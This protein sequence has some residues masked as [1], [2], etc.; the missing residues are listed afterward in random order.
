MH[1]QLTLRTGAYMCHPYP[2]E[3]F[4]YIQAEG[5]T[6]QIQKPTSSGA[7]GDGGGNLMGEMSAIL[8]RR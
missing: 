5:E 8:A 3:M 4:L 7:S 1:T 2:Q 6:T